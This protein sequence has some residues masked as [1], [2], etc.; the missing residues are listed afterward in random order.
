MKI[1][2]IGLGSM[3]KRRIRLLKQHFP[4]T[5]ISGIDQN[6]ERM[7]YCHREYGIATYDS[8][9]SAVKLEKFDCA[10]VCTS[11][12]GHSAV[13]GQCLEEGLHVFT[14]I[15]LVS[16]GY[17]ENMQS[18]REKN[19]KLFLSSSMIYR[20]EMQYLYQKVAGL[21]EPVSYNYHVGQYLPDWHP[22]ENYKDFFVGNRRTNGCREILAIELP[23]IT[24]VFGPINDIKVVRNRLT[25]LNIDYDDCYMILLSHEK[26][27]IGVLMAEVVARE[28]VRDL[29]VVGEH[30]FFSWQGTPDQFFQKNLESGQLE[31]IDLYQDIQRE[32]GYNQTIVENQYVNEMKQF[33]G[34]L[35]G[36]L[37]VVYG[38][39]DDMKIL[40][41]IDRIENE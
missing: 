26:G 21:R 40:H 13:I 3:G 39:E 41:I 27:N 12:L 24:R 23:W 9:E 17:W 1:V 22:W 16:D 35:E 7:D 18:A 30:I 10:F 4:G 29:K 20:N 36:K 33:F 32:N 25:G 31:K 11:P 8:L 15:N 6:P 34:E 28:A 19:L 14:E 37:P 38:F 2:V 5:D